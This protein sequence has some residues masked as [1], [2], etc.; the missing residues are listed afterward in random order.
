MQEELQT[1]GYWSNEA[2]STL[3]ANLTD[4]LCTVQQDKWYVTFQ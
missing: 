1:S 2:P 4:Q 3:P